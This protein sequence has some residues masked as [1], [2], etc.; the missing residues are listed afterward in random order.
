MG[1]FPTVTARAGANIAL[2]KYWGKRDV[3]K[4][5][6]AAGSLGLTV[7]ALTSTVSVTFDER[8]SEDEL[9]LDGVVASEGEQKRLTRWLDS[10]RQRAN[11]SARANVDSKNNFPTASGLASSASAF[12]ALSLAATRA[13]GLE[14]SPRELSILARLGS[15]SAARAVFG[16][17]VVM[18]PAG[19]AYAESID[20]CRDWPLRLVIAI[21]AGGR[22]K[23]FG[24]TNAM[25]ACRKTSPLY[26]AWLQT[27]PGDVDAAR[28]A[29]TARDF[30]A[31]GTVTEASTSAMHAC[32]MAARPG[33]WYFEP[34]TLACVERVLALRTEGHPAY[35]TMDAGPH[36]KVLT[37]E[38][39]ERTVAA[40]LQAI[41]GVSEVR[42]ASPGPGVQVVA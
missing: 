19:D 1:S 13:A 33:I 20:S 37:Y 40:A 21:V 22:R 4:N 29:I 11:I 41:A 30:K 5:L 16:G 27:V 25:E 36:V 17:L 23:K 6:P 35:F 2:V 8:L 28:A 42:V 18:H 15:G 32:A 12:A 34:V 38:P 3:D 31:L 39:H 24:S 14:L 7:D 10:V 9:V 26:E